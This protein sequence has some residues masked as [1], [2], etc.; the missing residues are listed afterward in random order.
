[1]VEGKTR[2]PQTPKQRR[3]AM[4]RN[5]AHNAAIAL[6]TI[7]TTF[8][9][10]GASAQRVPLHRSP[11][12]AAP[13]RGSSLRMPGQMHNPYTGGNH[14]NN[15]DKNRGSLNYKGFGD[16]KNGHSFH[17]FDPRGRR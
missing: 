13:V 10:Y 11:A 6:L 1:L 15:F 3:I 16:L 14:F 2:K 17:S 5:F 9:A 8:F 12:L 4:K 7:T